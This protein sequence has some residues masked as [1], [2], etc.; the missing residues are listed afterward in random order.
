M[1]SYFKFISFTLW[2]FKFDTWQVKKRDTWEDDTSRGGVTVC[3]NIQSL[4]CSPC[5]FPA[6]EQRKKRQ[7]FVSVAISQLLH[8]KQDFRLP[9]VWRTVNRLRETREIREITAPRGLSL[10]VRSRRWTEMNFSPA[11][12]DRVW[13]PIRRRQLIV[14][15]GRANSSARSSVGGGVCRNS[16]N[17]KAA[18]NTCTATGNSVSK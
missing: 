9:L 12:T 6:V 14:R 15:K 18:R 17:V 1:L 3:A 4:T 11:V 8:V 7:T 13:R 10:C 2:H 16:R 5:L